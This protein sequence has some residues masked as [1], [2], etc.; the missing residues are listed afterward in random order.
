MDW[1][2]WLVLIG[3][4]AIV[5]AI[6]VRLIVNKAKGKSSCSCGCGGCAMREMC[7]SNNSNKSKPSEQET[8]DKNDKI[9]PENNE[10]AE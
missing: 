6:V 2:G 9:E 5:V 3:L 1:R 7:H 4:I 10:K 8:V